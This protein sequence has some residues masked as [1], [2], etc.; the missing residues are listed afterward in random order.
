MNFMIII[1]KIIIIES[2]VHARKDNNTSTFLVFVCACFAKSFLL[3]S[4][5]IAWP[6]LL[7]IWIIHNLIAYIN[8]FPIGCNPSH[9][10]I[11]PWNVCLCFN[12]MLMNKC[13]HRSS[14]NS[15]TG[16]NNGIKEAK[17]FTDD[18]EMPFFK[19]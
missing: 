10:Q 15:S 18:L 8:T 16:F 6:L 5:D 12:C 13:L 4:I 1:K 17:Y 14:T 7:L 9:L 2:A 3:F 19:M 11:K